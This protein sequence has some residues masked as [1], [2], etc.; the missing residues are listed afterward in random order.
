MHTTCT[1]HGDALFIPEQFQ[2]L[3]LP[4]GRWTNMESV[5]PY[6]TCALHLGCASTMAMA[7]SNVCRPANHSVELFMIYSE[8]TLCFFIE[9]F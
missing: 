4:T 3:G 5:S 7:F 2:Y 1:F 6:T 9:T 8:D